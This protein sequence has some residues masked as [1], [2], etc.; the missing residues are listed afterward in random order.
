VFLDETTG[1]SEKRGV[2]VSNYDQEQRAMDAMA[3]ELHRAATFQVMGW[4]LLGFGGI[5]VCL[6]WVGFRTGS[7]FWL[8][9]TI[10]E[11]GLGVSL[12]LTG[13]YLRSRAGRYISRLGPST[14]RYV[15]DAGQKAA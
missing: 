14:T 10:I 1:P 5:I 6:V 2:Q 12:V 3:A 13:H 9:W 7:Y 4:L 8:Y 11:G 15:T